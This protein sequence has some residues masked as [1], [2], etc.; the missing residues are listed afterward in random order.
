MTTVEMRAAAKGLVR[1]H[2]R[3]APCFGRTEPQQHAQVYLN[4]LLLGEG[5]KSVEPL[6]LTFAERDEDAGTQNRVLGLQ[7]FLTAS[8]WQS[9]DV[10]REIQAVFVEDLAPSAA[11]PGPGIIGIVD[12]SSFVKKGTESVGVARQWCGRLGKVD[13]CQTGVFVVGTTPAGT[14]LLDHQLYLP[15]SWIGDAKRR[16]QT[17]VPKDTNFQ[18]KPQIATSLLERI[19][20]NGLV[21]FD[22]VVADEE[23]GRNGKFLDA[24]ENRGQRYL[25]EV[26]TNTTVWTVDPSTAP[27]SS[28]PGRPPEIRWVREV[29]AALPAENWQCLQVREGTARPLVYQFARVRVWA[30]RHRQAGAPIWLLFQRSLDAPATIKYY[31]SNAGAEETL[32]TLALV[33]G[34]RWRVEEFFEDSK[35]CLGMADYEARA[36]TSWHHHMSLVALAHLFVTLTR[37]DLKRDTPELTLDMAVAILK[38]VLTRPKLNEQQALEILEYHLERN[39]TAKASHYKT[40]RKKHKKVKYK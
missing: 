32:G 14:G 25:V 37:K 21:K 29:A 18:T 20:A 1:F 35:G 13:N 22:W 39:R 36:W 28:A 34:G 8:P 2:V 7:R 27:P 3:F 9:S 5:R 38:S 31:V 15:K 30:V 33:T 4:G 16:E 19:A 10:Q 23:F 24:L 12:G 6:A 26:P 40:W 11:G 17:R